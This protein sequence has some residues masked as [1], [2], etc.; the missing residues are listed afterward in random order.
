MQLAK[1]MSREED[2]M[3]FA[4]KKDRAWQICSLKRR[5]KAK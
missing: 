3:S 1:E 2:C 4:M 5:S